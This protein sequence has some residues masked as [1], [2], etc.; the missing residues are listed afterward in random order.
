[1]TSTNYGNVKECIGAFKNVQKEK[2][3]HSLD[4]RSAGT[5]MLAK[6]IPSERNGKKTSPNKC[7]FISLNDDDRDEDSNNQYCF[8]RLCIPMT[9]AFKKNIHKFE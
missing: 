2:K 8:A 6:W 1:L 9:I 3:F 4:E 5:W 7:G